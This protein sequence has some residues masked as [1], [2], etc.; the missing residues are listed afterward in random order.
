MDSLTNIHNNSESAPTLNDLLNRWQPIKAEFTAIECG[1]MHNALSQF[2]TMPE[3]AITNIPTAEQLAV[4][5]MLERMRKYKQEFYKRY[6]SNKPLK[7][8]LSYT[9]A[10]VLYKA[11]SISQDAVPGTPLCNLYWILDQ[12][13][14]SHL[15]PAVV[16]HQSKYIISKKWEE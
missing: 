10:Y 13:L 9:D 8:S 4:L 11:I 1:Y 12:K 2:L 16:A 15:P 3:Q 14:N 7:L 5:Y 6:D